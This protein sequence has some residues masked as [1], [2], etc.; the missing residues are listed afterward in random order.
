MSNI[1]VGPDRFRFITSYWTLPDASLSVD[2]GTSTP[3]KINNSSVPTLAA[4]Y[5]PPNQ[6]LEVGQS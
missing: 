2:V 4:S 1:V 3:I 5:L 6:K